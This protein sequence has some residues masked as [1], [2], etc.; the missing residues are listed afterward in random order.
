[1]IQLNKFKLNIRTRSQSV[2]KNIKS[3]EGLSPCLKLNKKISS[4]C[5]ESSAGDQSTLAFTD[6]AQDSPKA[7]I[8]FQERYTPNV[9]GNSNYGR[10]YGLSQESK[11]KQLGSFTPQTVE[12][13][14]SKAYQDIDQLT[15]YY[16]NLKLFVSG[17]PSRRKRVLSSYVKSS[18]P[19]QKKSDVQSFSI[20][21]KNSE[22]PQNFLLTNINISNDN[23]YNNVQ[24]KYIR[25]N[26]LSQSPKKNFLRESGYTSVLKNSSMMQ[27]KSP[28]QI[29]E[30]LEEKKRIQDNQKIEQFD[31]LIKHRLSKMMV[32]LSK[33]ESEDFYGKDT[34][35]G[36]AK[37]QK[38]K[39]SIPFTSYLKKQDNDLY[40]EKFK[41]ITRNPQ[42]KIQYD[43]LIK[44]VRVEN[45]EKH[46]ILDKSIKEEKDKY[47][48]ELL[49]R[50]PH[51]TT[52]YDI[53][54]QSQKSRLRIKAKLKEE[55]PLISRFNTQI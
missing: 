27:S 39:I 12:S 3:D 13:A 9:R 43:D 47:K 11:F 44:Q 53:L 10:T 37:Q 19:Y 21:L 50:S 16:Q 2:Q 55:L 15:K 49:S 6:V 4:Q 14:D 7:N 32:D 24:K 23:N 38:Q 36:E 18:S 29:Q 35:K 28:K 33:F 48:Q 41:E 42:M 54:A 46:Q 22:D 51:A 40:I 52:I 25:P 34:A 8:I 1:M 45:L 20:S 26:S 17:S 30:E 31:N 5:K